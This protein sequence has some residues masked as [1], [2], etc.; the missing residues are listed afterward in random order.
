MPRN[1]AMIFVMNKECKSHKNCKSHGLIFQVQGS[2]RRQMRRLAVACVITLAVIGA[3]TTSMVPREAN[4]QSSA[5]RGDIQALINRIDRLQREM[6]TLQRQVYGGRGAAADG[7]RG[8]SRGPAP[9]GVGS[10]SNIAAAMQIRLDEIETQMRN[11][12]GKV[13]ELRHAIDQIGKR[14]EKLAS[15][16]DFRLKALESRA[17]AGAATASPGGASA[18]ESGSGGTAFA[19]PRLR[20][21]PAKPGVLGTIPLKDLEQQNGASPRRLAPSRR[22]V[23]VAPKSAPAKL[24]PTPQA[25]YKY[26]TG[27]LFQSNYI[28]AE[29]AFTAFLAAHPNHKLA[30]NAQYWL[31]ESHYARCHPKSSPNQCAAAARAFADGYQKYPKS[32]KGPDNLLKLGFALGAINKKKSACATF[33]R[34]F[35]EFPKAAASIKSRARSQRKKLRCR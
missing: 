10:N 5:G 11:F 3:A 17:A 2:A 1:A 16:V 35:K 14:T 26:A 34:L 19:A 15:D 4:A 32:V 7:A 18:P 33:R 20:A 24:R 12:T 31:G 6:T 27:L 23:R 30:G 21:A 9:V 25:Q 28:G 13:E 29:Q 22:A 8:G